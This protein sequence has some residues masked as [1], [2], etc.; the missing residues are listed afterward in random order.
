MSKKI[1][2]KIFKKPSLVYYYQV[3][4]IQ[5]HWIILFEL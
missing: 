5:F 2:F 1:V 4:M 3:R